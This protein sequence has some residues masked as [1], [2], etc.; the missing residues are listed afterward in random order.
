MKFTYMY[1][2]LQLT[3]KDTCTCTTACALAAIVEI[4]INMAVRKHNMFR[5]SFFQTY[6]IVSDAVDNCA[7][8][9]KHSE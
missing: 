1:T 3:F 7:Q 9:C 6:G 5:K 4:K 2:V 8:M